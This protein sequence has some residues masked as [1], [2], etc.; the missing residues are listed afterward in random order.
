[1]PV[2]TAF[3]IAGALVVLAI[4]AGFALR[5][6]D[7][8]RRAGGDLR[9]RPDDLDAPLA[10][11]ATLVQF[12]TELCARCPQVRRLLG[13]I[14]QHHVGVDHVEVDLTNRNDLATRYRV[15]QTPTTFLVDSS[16]AVLSRWSGV[17]DRRAIS[18]ALTAV[19]NLHPQEQR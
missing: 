13:E 16:G 6:F 10:A 5:S 2:S 3:A 15:L 12:S 11:P 4:V 8:R 9:V 14:A 17:P 7:G 18:A 19:P 1:M